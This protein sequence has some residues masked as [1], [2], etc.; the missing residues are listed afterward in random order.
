MAPCDAFGCGTKVC[1]FYLTC[2]CSENKK[3]ASRE[4]G[5]GGAW[6]DLIYLWLDKNKDCTEMAFLLCGFGNVFHSLSGC[7]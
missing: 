5:L 1:H 7:H 6:S 4:C 2:K 3:I